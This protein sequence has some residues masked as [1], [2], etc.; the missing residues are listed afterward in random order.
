MIKKELAKDPNL[1]GEDWS[2]YYHYFVFSIL[3]YNYEC[4]KSNFQKLKIKK[5][6][7]FLPTFKKKNTSKRRVPHVVNKKKSYTPF[8]PA[9]IPSK[10]DLQL[11]SGEYFLNES[12]RANKKKEEKISAAKLKSAEKKRKREEEFVPPTEVDTKTHKKKNVY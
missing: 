6:K 12:Q 10:I 1:A 11:E 7:R 2:R 4:F 5:K 3:K 8:P 9:P